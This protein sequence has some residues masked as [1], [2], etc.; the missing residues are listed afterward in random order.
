M[1][2]NNTNSPKILS[3][4]LS[5][6][7]NKREILKKLRN[8]CIV[9]SNKY[10][11]KY[12]KYKRVDEAIEGFNSLISASSIACIITGMSIPPLLVASAILS[13][14]SF[15]ITRIQDKINIK[16][17]YTNY[18]LSINQYSA[19]G[20]EISAVLSKNNLST[21]DYQAYIEEIND[22]INLIS[23]SALII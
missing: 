14:S 2:C 5:P 7:T 1:S 21:K 16:S 8:D 19:L 12:K 10:K 18:N 4:C 23:D 13:G 17:K 9:L 6:T 15:I 3:Q 22:K 11:K 20:R